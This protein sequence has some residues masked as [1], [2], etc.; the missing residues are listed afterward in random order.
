MTSSDVA[1]TNHGDGTW[2]IA[3][4]NGDGAVTFAA[5]EIS[6]INLFSYALPGGPADSVTVY[7]YN[8]AYDTYDLVLGP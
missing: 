6:D 7:E 2:T 3:F 8:S 1:F 4:A 5:N